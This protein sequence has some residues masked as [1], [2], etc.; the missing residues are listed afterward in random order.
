MH[1]TEMLDWLDRLPP[2]QADA[3]RIAL[4]AAP[5]SASDRF[6]VGL[7]VLNLLSDIAEERPARL[8]R[9]SR[10]RSASP[11]FRARSSGPAQLGRE[12]LPD[13]HVLPRG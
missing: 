9:W 11:R 7:A 13:T 12:G 10:F 4:G 1:L 6:V 3:L 5:G 8:L 2:P